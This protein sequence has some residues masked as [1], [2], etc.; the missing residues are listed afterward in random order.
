M[1]PAATLRRRSRAKPRATRPL[2]NQRVLPSP[3]ILRN[4]RTRP[5]LR[6][7]L[8][9][10]RRPPEPA[11]YSFGSGKKLVG[12]DLQVATYRTR[13]PAGRNCYWERLSGL[14]GTLGDVIANENMSGPAVVTIGPGDVAFNSTGCP[15]WTQD[16]SPVTKS[17]TDP[18]GEGNYIVNVDIAPG[19]WK[20]S[21]TS[22]NCYW[23]RESGFSGTLSD[24]IAN[25]NSTGGTIVE[26]SAS[27]KGFNSSGCGTWTKAN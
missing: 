8:R 7:R 20:S 9:H 15:R 19:V 25:D 5:S 3:P 2:R 14:G 26:I 6:R 18:F 21:A 22:G 4:P 11:G 17:P 13:E 12:S 1:Q 10:P 24:V 16:L 23:Q 27:D